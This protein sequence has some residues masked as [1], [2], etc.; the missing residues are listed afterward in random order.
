MRST[1]DLAHSLGLHMV[2]EGVEDAESARRLTEY[3]CDIAQGHH[4]SRP[5]PAAEL[6]AW[7][8][9]RGQDDRT[10]PAAG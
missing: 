5:V 1:V 2:A 3:G 4:Y 6:S 8:A 9:E 10:L 7:L